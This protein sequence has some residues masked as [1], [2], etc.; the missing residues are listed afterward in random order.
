MRFVGSYDA[1]LFDAGDT[2]LRPEPS[3]SEALGG[4]LRA[5]GV[6]V[7]DGRQDRIEEALVSAIGRLKE[8]G[9]SFSTSHEESRGFWTGLYAAVLAD[10][11]VP[12]GDGAL[13]RYL[14][15]EFS[16]PERYALFPDTLPALRELSVRG[17]RLGVL[18]NFEAWLADILALRGVSPLLEC[19]V[20]SGVEGVEKP[21]ERIFRT[22][23]DR[24]GLAPER[25]LYVGDNV[26]LDIEPA[27]GLGMG[28][29]LIDRW[30][31]HPGLPRIQSLEQI[32]GI[33]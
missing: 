1:I 21:D 19:T 15:G 9:R 29:L 24:L 30:D 22:A 8:D 26:R 14:Y 31:R 5:R 6:A 33:L 11:G 28:A 12:D 3:F 20:I 18:S 2:L 4:L 17:F 7:P 16:K 13:A 23:L 25:V 10:L 27:L 32:G